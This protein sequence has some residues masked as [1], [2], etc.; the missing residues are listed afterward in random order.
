[1]FQVRPS[2]KYAEPA[3]F[4]LGELVNTCR[5]ARNALCS[6]DSCHWCELE[7]RELIRLPLALACT[8]YVTDYGSLRVVP[9]EVGYARHGHENEK[10]C[11]RS[12]TRI[13]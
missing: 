11:S 7:Q 10:G 9:N 12:I 3:M 13:N 8:G 1:M 2:D 4:S 5:Q 6:F